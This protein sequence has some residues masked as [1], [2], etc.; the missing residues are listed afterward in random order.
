[1]TNASTPIL[2]ACM[3]TTRSDQRYKGTAGDILIYNRALSP[4][5]IQQLAD[6]S[7]V[8]LSG[9][10]L[11]PRRRLWAVS[12]GGAPVAKT[13]IWARQHETQVIGGGAL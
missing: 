7:N 11:P 8:M 9:L 1:V 4:A 5:E 2:F 3:Y 12:G 13:W 10:I 6:P